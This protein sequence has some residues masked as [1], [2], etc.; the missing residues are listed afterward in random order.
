MH[1]VN[2]QCD[3]IKNASVHEPGNPWFYE[4]ACSKMLL[5]NFF[6]GS[7]LLGT[8]VL[9]ISED[10]IQIVPKLLD[11]QLPYLPSYSKV[12][13]HTDPN[14]P[15]KIIQTYLTVNFVYNKKYKEFYS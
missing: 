10:K 4:A 15:D 13:Q 7:N 11:L 1:N 9:V 5:R 3:D 12:C 6:A 8:K 2:F 14:N